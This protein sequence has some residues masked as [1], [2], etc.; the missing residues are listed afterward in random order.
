VT[1]NYELRVGVGVGVGVGTL[2]ESGGW[3][4]WGAKPEGVDAGGSGEGGGP[5]VGG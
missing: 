3:G 2:R 5:V 4:G 1:G